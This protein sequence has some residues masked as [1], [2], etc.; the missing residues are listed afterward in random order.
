[1]KFRRPPKPPTEERLKR[2]AIAYLQRYSSSE[3]NLRQVLQRKVM[4]AAMALELNPDD[5][6]DM[7]RDTVGF[8]VRNGLVD[9]RAYAETK[10]AG[11]RRRGRSTSRIKAT[12]VAKGVSKDLIDETLDDDPKS[13]IAA[14]MRFAKRRRF[15]PWRTTL[16]VDHKL[17]EKETAALCR[18]GFSYA[19][20]RKIVT[21]E[22]VDALRQSA[23]DE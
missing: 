10:I 18:A 8:C 15:G 22:N 7:I 9:D 6:Q 23:C 19:L 4:R 11:L 5:F 12:L 14:A 17:M 20:A 21:A 3:D 13:E 1:M 2:S 16:A